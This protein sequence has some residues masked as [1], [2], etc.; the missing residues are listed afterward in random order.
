MMFSFHTNMF[1]YLLFVY[2]YLGYECMTIK[3]QGVK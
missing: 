2:M 3:S 1:G